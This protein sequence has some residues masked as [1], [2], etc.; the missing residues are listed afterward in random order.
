MKAKDRKDIV[1]EIVT[2]KVVHASYTK[3]FLFLICEA[4][5][6]FIAVRVESV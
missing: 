3:G 4:N 1:G 2:V 5:Y 6:T